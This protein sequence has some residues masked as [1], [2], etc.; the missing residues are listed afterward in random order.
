MN[1]DVFPG[2]NVF[3][4]TLRGNYINYQ[5]IIFFV[6]KQKERLEGTPGIGYSPPEI[7][8]RE[9]VDGPL[10]QCTIEFPDV[11]YLYQEDRQKARDYLLLFLAARKGKE[12]AL[13]ELK[14][15]R[16]KYLLGKRQFYK[17]V[18]LIENENV[19]H[20]GSQRIHNHY[21][22]SHKGAKLLELVR[23]GYPV[24]DFSILTNEWFSL[25]EEEKKRNLKIALRNLEQLTGERLNDPENP[26][27]FAIRCAMPQYIPGL[28]P[29][30][31]NAGVVD[32]T[33]KALKR[34]FGIKVA[35]K[36]YLNNLL[37]LYSLLFHNKD[38]PLLKQQ[39]Y[40]LST[41]EIYKKIQVYYDL[42]HQ[43]DAQLLTDAPY[44]ISFLLRKAC[45]F[46]EKNKDLPYTLIKKKTFPSFILQKMVW[47][48][49]DQDSYP[50]ILYSRH[51]RTGLG[52]QVESRKNIFG[53][54]IMSGNIETID[55]EY[56]QRE[57]I[58]DKY[59]AIYHIS[60]LLKE[61]EIANKSP[62]T[63]E[64]AAESFD[65]MHMFAILQINKSELT[66]RA[67]LLSAMELY[68][69][70]VIGKDV[71]INLVQ[72]YHLR[73]IYSETIDQQSISD[74]VYF[75][76]GV[77]VLPRSAIS[78]RIY[79]SA[80]KALEVVKKGEKVCYCKE[81]FK[82]ADAA[83]MK[84]VDAIISLNPAAIHVV[85]AC[86]GYG[87]PAFLNLESYGVKM[88]DGSLISSR[89]L[90]IDEGDWITISSKKKSIFLGQAKFTPARFQQYLNGQN[91]E[92]E[93][94][95]ATVF[96]NMAIAYKAYKNLVCSL[97][98]SDIT[99]LDNLIKLVRNDLNNDRPKA[100]A[101]INDW[102]DSNTEY[103]VQQILKCELGSHQDQY[104]IYNLMSTDRKIAFS[105]MIIP[106]CTTQGLSGYRAGSFMLGRFSCIQ[107]PLAFW[108]ALKPLEIVFLLNEHVLFQKY[109][110]VLH[111]VGERNIGRARSAILE[112]GLEEIMVNKAMASTFITLKLV[113]NDWIGIAQ[114]LNEQHE[115]ETNELIT[116]LQ[117]PYGYF[118][119]Y[120]ASWSLTP[121]K[122]I[123][124]EEGI[125]LPEAE[126]V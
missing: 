29:T 39:Q 40:F 73:Q 83:I 31:L 120:E 114:C 1:A 5:N 26:L 94:K 78:A 27:V 8:F 48:V 89:N 3:D 43:K 25:D 35:G 42:V 104:R 100:E 112:R 12:E 65:N 54:A 49:K 77:S 44:Q 88:A 108:K 63:I 19:I 36:I 126:F 118:Y 14:E 15:L 33:H 32:K 62:V 124:E 52:C 97:D 70:G 125:P 86:R 79:F 51:S 80:A 17:D 121:F 11:H 113:Q 99:D 28:M 24:P 91:L 60:P 16:K 107:H 123:C 21:H 7:E 95:E 46:F 105:R 115:A 92:L 82:P 47:T 67:C 111:H 56:F 85:T 59:P 58:K 122:Q 68:R 72:P 20:S 76:A 117:K 53:E 87:I 23:E 9:R 38:I 93:P 30:Y 96:N 41:G 109:M 50:G 116:L 2:S 37:T 34:R 69:N 103:Y 57:E 61:L 55:A 102:F 10:E 64:F 22:I 81:H 66:G 84:E 75:S 74:L 4:F 18:Y 110:Y 119:N 106:I 6:N 45:E 90:R 98:H 13:N 71:V 101:Y